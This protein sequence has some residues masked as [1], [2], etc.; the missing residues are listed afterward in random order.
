MNETEL[1]KVIEE[2][3]KKMVGQESS[4]ANMQESKVQPTSLGDGIFEDM[5]E[6]IQKAKEA[7]VELHKMPLEFREKI[8][9]RIREKIMENKETP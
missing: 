4:K 7:Q 3:V 5:E 9:T 6:A 8:I 1:Q 2:V